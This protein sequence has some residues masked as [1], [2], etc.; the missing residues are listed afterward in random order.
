M[1]SAEGERIELRG[2]G[3]SSVKLICDLLRKKE[4]HEREASRLHVDAGSVEVYLEDEPG[5]AL[6]LADAGIVDCCTVHVE[7]VDRAARVK[8][9]Q[10]CDPWSDLLVPVVCLARERR[11]VSGAGSRRSKQSA[12]GVP[13]RVSER[14]K[15]KSPQGIVMYL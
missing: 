9:A 2:R 10:R 7:W 5:E 3:T 12:S 13:R 11:P 15:H 8:A 6:S 1:V 14:P 4:G